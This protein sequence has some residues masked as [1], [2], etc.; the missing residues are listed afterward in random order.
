VTRFR[1]VLDRLCLLACCSYA[2]NRWVVKPHTHNPFLRYHFNDVLLI[3]CALPPLLLLQRWM[4][5]RRH[6]RPPNAAEIAFHL[7]IWS[8]LFEVIGP[9]IISRATG[10]PWDVVSYVAGGGLAWLWWNRHELVQMRP[11]EL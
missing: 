5:L 3:P 6:D 9:H 10:D 7:V 8:I 11:H 4:N 2:I 1:Y